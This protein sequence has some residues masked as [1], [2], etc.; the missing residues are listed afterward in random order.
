MIGRGEQRWLAVI[1]ILSWGADSDLS[2]GAGD[3]GGRGQTAEA[4]PQAPGDTAPASASGGPG[5]RHP[6]AEKRDQHH[7]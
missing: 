7:M 1:L 2:W 3:H 6:P 4:A 5:Q